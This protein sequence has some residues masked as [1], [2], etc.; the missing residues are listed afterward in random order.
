MPSNTIFFKHGIQLADMFGEGF[1]FGYNAFFGF[2]VAAGQVLI[3][4]GALV[5]A[6]MIL[7]LIFNTIKAIL[8]IIYK[9]I[10]SLR[11][12][13]FLAKNPDAL[14]KMITAKEEYEK[15]RG[16]RIWLYW[17]DCDGSSLLSM[18]NLRIS[19]SESHDLWLPRRSA[20]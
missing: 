15:A 12:K 8:Y 1:S 4:L 20:K 7:E 14:P 16:N 17:D 9:N 3:F 18:G 19:I 2:L 6:G 13:R 10:T 11:V 5:F